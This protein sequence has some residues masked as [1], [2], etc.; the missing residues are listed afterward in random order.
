MEN[1]KKEL[2]K[3]AKEL[4]GED[5]SDLPHIKKVLDESS[6]YENATIGLKEKA[7]RMLDGNL[8]DLVKFLPI[9]D[10]IADLS[11]DETH[12]AM[13][14]R[15][16]GNLY[17][18][19]RQLELAANCFDQA[20]ELYIRY[21]KEI[22]SQG[23]LVGNISILFKL[24]R[25][26]E[27]VKLAMQ[28][29][30]KFESWKIWDAFARVCF[31]LAKIYQ[32]EGN[33]D[34]SLIFLEKGAQNL[35][36]KK[37]QRLLN[38][39]KVNIASIKLETGD[40]EDARSIFQD[41]IKIEEKENH[42]S[43]LADLRENLAFIL[44]KIDGNFYE[45]LRL[46]KNSRETFYDLMQERKVAE[47]QLDICKILIHLHDLE[48]AEK[49]CNDMLPELERNADADADLLG[50]FYYHSGFINFRIG[51][52]NKKNRSNYFQKARERYGQAER[53]YEETGDEISL[54][55][56]TYFL[57]MLY[58]DQNRLQDS[59]DSLTRALNYF[60][61]KNL[62]DK[63]AYVRL[64][65]A[66]TEIERDKPESAVKLLHASL[67]RASLFPQLT[68]D[69]YY[70]LGHIEEKRSDTGQALD[71][72]LKSIEQ[73]NRI[74][75][76]LT[77]HDIY[78]TAYFAG[79]IK[80]YNRAA[81]IY[82]QQNRVEEAFQLMEQAKSRNLINLMV[83][84]LKLPPDSLLAQE[85]DRLKKQLSRE[86]SRLRNAPVE[87]PPEQG[88]RGETA[89][90]QTQRRMRGIE[91][92]MRKILTDLPLESDVKIREWASFQRVEQIKTETLQRGLDKNEV[93]LAYYIA[94]DNIYA[95]VL[96]KNHA[97]ELITMAASAEHVED[98]LY[99]FKSQLKLQR[100]GSGMNYSGLLSEDIGI[101]LEDS[102][103][104]LIKDV[105]E[106]S[107]A[108][109]ESHPSRLIIVPYGD[110]HG[111][112]FHAAYNNG[113]YLIED[114]TISYAP[115]S[116]VWYYCQQK[117]PLRL[118]RPVLVAFN[119]GDIPE[120]IEETNYLADMFPKNQYPDLIYRK[121]EEAT[122]E[123]L[124]RDALKSDFLHLAVHGF[125]HESHP[126]LSRLF[127][128][129]ESMTVHDIMQLELS[130]KLATLSACET[131]RS[132]ITASDELV[133]LIRGFF[134]VGA[135]S[136]VVSLWVAPDKSARL[137]MEAFYKGVKAGKPLD[138]SLR[139]AQIELLKTPQFKHPFYWSLFMLVGRSAAAQI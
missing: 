41:L 98:M 81:R 88:E 22:E 39:I 111:F 89:R 59:H 65:L 110:L 77:H 29:V 67:E 124:R 136:L 130:A 46:L 102:Y 9:F 21:G 93:I 121:Q 44:Y 30:N 96:S 73:I 47:C 57:G 8:D 2:K 87:L 25:R 26:E 70:E 123:N 90:N 132:E 69:I 1:W 134:A 91:S 135:A 139:Q 95:F 33:L 83:Q 27:A 61:A 109:K 115:S 19:R 92:Q 20:S 107:E 72:Y 63:A 4:L 6:D 85:Y 97:L 71:H 114:Y 66:K 68:A 37:H 60:E 82:I 53:L 13:G 116:Q 74:A 137:L 3:I 18:K 42:S 31:A 43:F 119:P 23:S 36:E 11:G 58:R 75:S 112:P 86:L 138:E 34:Q 62:T 105:L 80:A 129:G 94:S 131:G 122:L 125:F 127:L 101:I 104:I 28:L 128:A 99:E 79:E 24:K 32:F 56:T 40:Y 52:S 100:K 106:K 120:V 10:R 49:I 48:E 113:R 117:E 54:H 45:A 38:K 126:L 17:R 16:K 35:D 15:V 64:E 55:I 108:F 50:S 51:M 118:D 7:D 5:Q 76:S 14:L 84:S 103:K 78:H 133:G 12:R